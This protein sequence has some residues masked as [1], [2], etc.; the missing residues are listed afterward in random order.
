MSQEQ[1]NITLPWDKLP[2][3]LR[4]DLMSEIFV[5]HWEIQPALKNESSLRMLGRVAAM[6][7]FMSP[8]KLEPTWSEAWDAFWHK[9]NNTEK[10][11][12]AS[13]FM[14]GLA[15]PMGEAR[16]PGDVPFSEEITQSTQPAQLKKTLGKILS[17][18]S[19]LDDPWRYATNPE[20][21]NLA[22]LTT[23]IFGRMAEGK[24]ATLVSNHPGL[25]AAYAWLLSGSSSRYN[26]V[27]GRNWPEAEK[28]LNA[29]NEHVSVDDSRG[30]HDKIFPVIDKMFMDYDK[31]SQ[32]PLLSWTPW[33]KSRGLMCWSA[34]SITNK[35]MTSGSALSVPPLVFDRALDVLPKAHGVV[36]EL[37]NPPASSLLTAEEIK[38]IAQ[39][40][41]VA[42]AWRD[43]VEAFM[44]FEGLGESIRSGKSKWGF[45]QGM[46]DSDHMPCALVPFFHAA[47]KIQAALS[48]DSKFSEIIGLWFQANTNRYTSIVHQKKGSNGEPSDEDFFMSAFGAFREARL[49]AQISD[50]PITRTRL[51][52]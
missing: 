31:I 12:V 48:R 35:P 40:W 39:S 10:E 37:F 51:K 46:K 19:S 9:L 32:S 4:M 43:H 23:M 42:A 6:Q 41:M 28:A 29:F 1:H 33:W 16:T 34:A 52:V 3:G 25:G 5:K 17:D 30:W 13:G 38:S 27:A 8:F 26:D 15:N 7:L 11:M 44:H 45:W 22:K 14:Q 21:P 49:L 18:I 2:A 50:D 20:N 36:N 47:P 24:H